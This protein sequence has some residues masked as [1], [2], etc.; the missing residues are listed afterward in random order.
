MSTYLT[1]TSVLIDVL[2]G[3]PDRVER[4]KSLVD[5]G[6]ILGC[7]AITVGE[8]FA[9]MRQPGGNAGFFVFDPKDRCGIGQT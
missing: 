6:H 1:D 5:A 8:L 7:S 3:V 2:R 4:L 9:G